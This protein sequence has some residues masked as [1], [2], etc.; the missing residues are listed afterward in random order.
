MICDID[1][2]SLKNK[3]YL[4]AKHFISYSVNLVIV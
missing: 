2:E 1:I 3:S 4:L